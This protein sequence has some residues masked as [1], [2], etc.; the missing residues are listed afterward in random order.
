MKMSEQTQ[1][2]DESAEEISN[3][4]SHG[5]G[6]RGFKKRNQ[7]FD[8]YSLVA[9]N[10]KAINE[11]KYEEEEEGRYSDSDSD[12]L[13]GIQGPNEE[14][15]EPI[16]E[17][18]CE[19]S[20]FSLDFRNWNDVVHVC[21]GKHGDKSSFEALSWT[22]KHW[23]TPFTTLCLLHVFPLVR[24][25]PSPLGKLPRSH[26][27]KPHVNLYLDQ[28]KCKRKRLLQR[29]IDL[30]L[31]SQVKV[32]TILNEGDNVAKSIVDVINNVGVRKLVLG[33]TKSNLRKTV[34]RRKKAI[35]GDVVKKAPENCDV[36]IICEGKDVIYDI[37]GAASPRSSQ[38]GTPRSSREEHE[39]SR[40]VPY[41]KLR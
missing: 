26:V 41:K 6:F 31:A 13:F 12:S 3:C 34:S 9:D 23:I 1:S 21:V 33:I 14:G 40:I 20:V 38:S 29:F 17:E 24:L 39:A 2:N 10:E 11:D 22:L 32:E 4:P 28:H 19:S 8:D 5:G 7:V 16:R 37:V 25:I 18:D 15:L 36:K 27:N 30:C 35:A